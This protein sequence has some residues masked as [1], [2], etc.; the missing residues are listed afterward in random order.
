MSKVNQIETA[1]LELEGGAFQK[2]ID[3]YLTAKGYEKINSIGS[4]IGNNKVRKGTPDTLIALDNGH[5][6]FAEHTT[7][8]KDIFDKFSDDIDKCLDESKTGVPVKNIDSILLCYTS[9]LSAAEIHTLT[10]QCKDSG[11]LLNHFGIHTIAFDLYQKYPGLAKDFLGIEID[12]HQLVGID[13]FVKLYET[14]KLATPLHTKFLKRST[15]VEDVISLLRSNTIVTIAGKSGSGKS[16]LA[17]E[18]MRLFLEENPTYKPICVYNRGADLFN[19]IR[20]YLSDSGDHLLFVDD[21]NRASGFQ[22]ILQHVQTK[23][24]DQNIKI[25]VTVRDYALEKVRQS[26]ISLSGVVEYTLSHFEEKDIKELVSNEFGIKNPSYQDRIVEISQCNPRLAVMAAKVAAENNTLDSIRDVSQLYDSFFGSIKSDLEG[27]GKNDV[28]KVAGIISFFR[29]ADRS[30]QAFMNIVYETFNINETIFWGSVI[31]LHNMEVVDIWE[32]EVVKISD[33]VLATYLY[34]LVFFK[35]EILSF[36]ELI[37]KTFPEYKRCL[38]DSLNP[39]L[40]AFGLENL[41]PVLNKC[42]DATWDDYSAGEVAVFLDYIDVFWFLRPTN[43]LVFMKRNIDSLQPDTVAIEDVSFEKISN[44]GLPKFLNPISNFKY[45]SVDGLS[46]ALDLLFNYYEKKYTDAG[47]VLYSLTENF[48]FQPE[49]YDNGYF[50]QS[51]VIDKLIERAKDGDDVLFSKLLIALANHYLAT[52]YSTTRSS[53][54]GNA[55]TTTRFNLAFCDEILKIRHNI[56]NFLVKNYKASVYR[57]DILSV[58]KNYSYSGIEISVSK[59][60][61]D[62]KNILLSGIVT[63]LDSSDLFHCVLAHS[64]FK[65]MKRFNVDFTISEINRFD[66]TSYKFYRLF[67][68]RFERLQ[69]KLDHNEY[70]EYQKKLL[71]KYT[72]GLNIHELELIFS[73]LF[74]VSKKLAD[75]SSWNISQGLKLALEILA[76]QG[77]EY[78]D[79]IKLIQNKNFYEID[80][81]YIVGDLIHVCGVEKTYDFITSLDT[82]DKNVWLFSFYRHKKPD[83]TSV[84]D[85]KEIKFLY[86]KCAYNHV[87]RNLDFLLNYEKHKKG[88]VTEVTGILLERARNDEKYSIF[89]ADLFNEYG[90]IYNEKEALFF[91]KEV[92]LEDA[93]LFSCLSKNHFDYK[94]KAL[95]TLIDKNSHFIN[96]YLNNKFSSKTYLSKHDDNNNYTE[97]W[98]RSDYHSIFQ[99]ITNSILQH[100]LEGRSFNYLECFFSREA[101][102]AGD[103]AVVENQ[104]A[105]LLGEIQQRHSD[106]EYMSLLFYVIVTFKLDR[107]VKLYSEFIKYSK[108]FEAFKNL[109]TEPLLN[110]WSGSEVPHIQKKIDFYNELLAKFQTIYF[111]DHKVFIEERISK[112]QNRMALAKKRDF[113]EA[114]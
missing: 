5:Y 54:G 58:F 59:I 24:D 112:L 34:Y 106:Q 61:E 33:Q 104:N 43:V 79:F 97:L 89:L 1:L 80:P 29:I 93:Y 73:D 26:C 19:D 38:L 82:E 75:N 67:T 50:I 72:K 27:L 94:V 41:K 44:G 22:Y 103:S 85:L 68:D 62:D 78:F 83:E 91:G 36:T 100:H 14:S 21:A 114:M 18:C 16:R 87:Y 10:T 37:V 90:A 96:R 98:L 55:F 51:E 111:L 108:E 102:S 107:R 12:T 101:N 56:L 25:I 84:D 63:Q 70:G 76:K 23:R 88:F 69:L 77:N 2:L 30:N 40:S 48:G 28:L 71:N 57:Q 32:N 46:N 49:S 113:S 11:V 95:L 53:S 13:E 86:E 4:V 47:N 81:S 20:V 31:E 17:L 74:I 99:T 9:Q 39:T 60:V 109:P 35:E 42:I 105:F 7:I 52:H 110:S 66:T 65:L 15:E 64:Y 3:A 45:L 8:K 92:L 6:I